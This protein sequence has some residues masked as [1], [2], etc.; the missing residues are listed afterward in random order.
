MS[1]EET[2]G[3]LQ[4][5]ANPSR[6]QADQGPAAE[7][8]AITFEAAMTQLEVVVRALENGDLPLEQALLQFQSGMQLVKLCRD[9]LEAA[10]QKVEMVMATEQGLVQRSFAVEEY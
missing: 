8:F 6:A 7:G 5:T 3:N 2:I 10:Q 9:Q 4:P 1:A